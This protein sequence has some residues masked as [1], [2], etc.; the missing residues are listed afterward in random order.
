MQHEAFRTGNFDTHF[1]PRYFTPDRLD[2][3]LDE[4][5]QRAGAAVILIQQGG[6][7]TA[8][9]LSEGAYP[10]QSPRPHGA[11]AAEHLPE[12]RRPSVW[13]NAFMGRSR[14]NQSGDYAAV[15]INISP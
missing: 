10:D 11:F 4:D 5:Q 2:R 3:E 14:S 9:S 12:V 8:V 6:K 13:N 15:G 1:V 7:G